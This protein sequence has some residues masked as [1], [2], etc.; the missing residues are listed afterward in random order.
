MARSPSGEHNK[1][2]KVLAD[3]LLVLS[4]ELRSALETMQ[5]ERHFRADDVI[6][7]AGTS[8]LGVHFLHKGQVELTVEQGDEAPFKVTTAHPGEV[9][10][11]GAALSK[12]KHGATA[13][14]QKDT[15]TGFVPIA[16]LM[17]Y[18]REHPEQCIELSKQLST[19]LQCAYGQVSQMRT[20]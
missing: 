17:D 19:R 10:G 6:Y 7:S 8:C 20:R 2:S 13:V 3:T 5:Q 15:V 9:L 11:L 12:T 16:A 14:C 1:V 4:P 18:L